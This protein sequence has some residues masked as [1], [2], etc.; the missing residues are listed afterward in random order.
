M[1]TTCDIN[2]NVVQ[3]LQNFCDVAFFFLFTI[4]SDSCIYCSRPIYIKLIHS[5]GAGITG[6]QLTKVLIT[7][8]LVLAV[9]AEGLP[10]GKN[11]VKLYFR[12]DICT[13][14]ACFSCYN[15]IGCSKITTFQCTH[16]LSDH[17]WCKSEV[18]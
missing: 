1:N 2:R 3:Q 6:M 7:S 5:G 12:C 17:S 13:E 14:V 18:G 9:C 11:C 8:V 10:E 4:K 16:K 15:I